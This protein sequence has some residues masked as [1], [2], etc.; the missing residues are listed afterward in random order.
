MRGRRSLQPADALKSPRFA[1]ITTFARLPHSR[2]LSEV[3]AAFLGIPFD[4]ATTFRSGARFGPKAVREASLLLRPYNAALKV[5]PFAVLNVLDYGDIDVVPGYIE[6]TYERVEEQMATIAARGIR[7]LICGGDHSIT[8]PV[9]RALYKRLGRLSLVHIDAH[10]DCWDEYFGRKYNHGTVFRRALE[11]GLVEPSSSVHV[12]IRGPVYSEGDYEEV[13]KM[14]YRLITM[15]EVR[16]K[17]LNEALRQIL[18]IAQGPV[19]VSFDIDACDP[20]VAPGTGTPEVAGFLAHEALSLV[21]SLSPLEIVGF[22][23]VEV[24]PPYDVA[25]ITALL[26]SNLLYEA[27][28]AMA[29]NALRGRGNAKP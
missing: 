26:A 11:E 15:E 23:L 10:A 29:L 13:K 22:D 19:Y 9:L 20:S 17:G 5:A 27:L 24:S 25:G 16:G 28:S 2:D 12:G 14:G 21:R 4:D 3:D 6:D 1:G 7:P 8:L 18:S